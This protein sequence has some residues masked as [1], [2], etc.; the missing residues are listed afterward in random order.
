MVRMSTLWWTKSEMSTLIWRARR[1]CTRVQLNK[2]IPKPTVLYT[3]CPELFE[4]CWT[5]D[6][7]GTV[8]VRSVGFL[9]TLAPLRAH[10][11]VLS[12]RAVV[13]SDGGVP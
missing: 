11:A 10:I 3:C 1:K 6:S 2:N 7:A 8:V 13:A 12:A 9:P 5:Y 4:R